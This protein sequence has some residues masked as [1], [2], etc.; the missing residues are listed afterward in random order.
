[1]VYGQIYSLALYK[2]FHCRIPWFNQ[3]E[4]SIPESFVKLRYLIAPAE[5]ST[6]TSQLILAH[7]G[8]IVN[9]M[10]NIYSALFPYAVLTRDVQLTTKRKNKKKHRRKCACSCLCVLFFTHALESQKNNKPANK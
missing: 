3:S 4:L 6:A 2:V 9:S 1:M 8:P 7:D 10:I 5:F